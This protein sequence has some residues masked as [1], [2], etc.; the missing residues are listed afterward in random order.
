MNDRELT[1]L[2]LFTK[3]LMV[4]NQ[5]NV[6]LSKEI[7]KLK[8]KEY[9]KAKEIIKQ[10]IREIPKGKKRTKKSKQKEDDRRE[11]QLKEKEEEIRKKMIEEFNK[12]IE[13]IKQKSSP[14]VDKYFETLKEMIKI[15][16]K[17]KIT[18]MV[19]YGEAGLGK[20]YVT[21]KTLSIAKLFWF[22]NRAST[23][24]IIIILFL[25]L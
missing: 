10:K 22:S 6:D 17:Q 5:T 3:K 23:S 2:K 21:L 25:N 9:S 15:V 1:L 11:K 8:D 7:E 18:G 24:S 19:I 12:S 4:E 14:E 13:E 16:I 20:T